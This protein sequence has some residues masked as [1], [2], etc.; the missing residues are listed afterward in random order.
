MPSTDSF[1]QEAGCFNLML[2][3]QKGIVTKREMSSKKDHEAPK[4]VPG[5]GPAYVTEISRESSESRRNVNLK[6]EN[7]ESWKHIKRKGCLYVEAESIISH[8]YKLDL[9]CATNVWITVHPHRENTD[10]PVDITLVDVDRGTSIQFK[11]NRDGEKYCL[12]CDLRAGSYRLLPFTTGCRLRKRES[13]PEQEVP[14]VDI[15]PS[16]EIELSRPF[17]DTLTDIFEILDLD[18]NGLLSREEF[19]LFQLRSGREVDDEAWQFVEENFEMK[20]GELTKKGFTFL[21]LMDARGSEG[22]TKELWVTPSSM[23]YNKALRQDEACP[24]VIDIYAERCEP[25][26]VM[27][28]LLGNIEDAM[29]KLVSSKGAPQPLTSKGGKDVVLYTYR[30]GSRIITAVE[31][32]VHALLTIICEYPEI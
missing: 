20:K 31:N 32:K 11:D 2:R 1:Q 23:G 18:G 22:N 10:D 8:E 25:K 14:L 19:N 21:N 3:K 5:P 27:G 29:C 24:F 12:R 28:G 4:P 13:Q 9:P 30:T 6:P 17:R 26:M 7:L 16:G 15:S